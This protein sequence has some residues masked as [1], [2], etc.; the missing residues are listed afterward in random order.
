[1]MEFFQQL[2]HL[3]PYGNPQYFVYVIAATL[4]L[5]RSLFQETLCLV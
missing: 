1:M 2:P 3:E 5:Y 4:H